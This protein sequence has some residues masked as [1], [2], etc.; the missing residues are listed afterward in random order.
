[1]RNLDSHQGS[2]A[3]ETDEL[4]TSPFR[5]YL[6]HASSVHLCLAPLPRLERGTQ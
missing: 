3:Y 5:I 1:M 2:S 4:T 6:K